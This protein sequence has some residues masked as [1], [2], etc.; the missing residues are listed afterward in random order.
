[1][2]WDVL[3]QLLYFLSIDICDQFASISCLVWYLS[4]LANKFAVC[5]WM[6]WVYGICF[7]F[8]KGIFMEKAKTFYCHFPNVTASDSGSGIQ[9]MFLFVG[10]IHTRAQVMWVR[11]IL[12]SHLWCRIMLHRVALLS[13][14]LLRVWSTFAYF[15]SCCI[16]LKTPKKMS[17]VFSNSAL[18]CS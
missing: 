2:N 7:T 13:D 9:D 18:C 1:M 16:L 14:L 3:T 17:C 11:G 8:I 5:V 12:K 15:T 6:R 10:S 4:K